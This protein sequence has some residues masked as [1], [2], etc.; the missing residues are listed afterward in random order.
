LLADDT[1]DVGE[2]SSEGL[3]CGFYWTEGNRG[4]GW[5][6]KA[7]PTLKGGSTIGIPSPPAIWL[8]DGPIITPGIRDAERLQG[9]DRDWTAPVEESGK[10]SMRWKLVGNAV[11]VPIAAWIGHRLRE[12][13]EYAGGIDDP[14][15][16][17]DPWPRAAYNVGSGRRRSDVSAWPLGRKWADLAEFVSRDEASPL[18]FKATDGFLRRFEVSTLRKPPGFLEAM[19]AH[20]R[21][22]AAI[23]SGAF[24]RGKGEA[25]A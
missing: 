16:R 25:T 20:H 18:S 13:S 12:P 15:R 19:R 7:V 24:T 6:L 21:R 8:P 22:M 14:I 9:F 3:A 11:S 5:A 1:A 17:G 10:R 2:V 23:G 4:L